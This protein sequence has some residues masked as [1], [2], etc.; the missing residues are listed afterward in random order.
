MID[1]LCTRWTKINLKCL[2][3][4][5]EHNLKLWSI[6]IRIGSTSSKRHMYNSMKYFFEMN[7]FN[8]TLPYFCPWK[9]RKSSTF[10]ESEH[11]SPFSR[12]DLLAILQKSLD[13]AIFLYIFIH[14]VRLSGVRASITIVHIRKFYKMQGLRRN[15]KSGGT[16][17]WYENIQ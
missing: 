6:E 17:I 15:L 16:T 12:K 4:D 14:E 7:G 10:L 1:S 11:F 8:E 2:K 13:R 9:F 5:Y 3:I